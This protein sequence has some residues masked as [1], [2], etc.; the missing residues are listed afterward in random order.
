M[1]LITV[2]VGV[3]I[4]LTLIVLM[5]FLFFSQITVRKLKKNPQTRDEL[6]FEYISGWNIINAAQ[7]LAMP[8]AL[9]KKFNKTPLASLFA[10]SELLNRNTNKFDKI[11]AII[12]YWLFIFSGVFAAILVLLNSIGVF[13]S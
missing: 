13:E 2:L 8:N 3:L 4:A 11:L 6:G 12:F 9:I 10:D 7:A 1:S 5:L